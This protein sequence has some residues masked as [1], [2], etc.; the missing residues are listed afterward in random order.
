MKTTLFV[1]LILTLFGACCRHLIES[2][3]AKIAART[4]AALCSLLCLIV[5]AGAARGGVQG[6]PALEFQDESAAFQ[7]LSADT[8]D[9]VCKEA[10]RLLA[11][12]LTDGIAKTCGHTPSSCR[13]AIDRETLCVTAV[14]V[15]FSKED[16]L[17]SSYEVKNYVR[18]Q[19]GMEAAVEVM[20]E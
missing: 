9:A 1:C 13:T 15:R 12:R 16:L 2:A 6:F 17:L 20:F 8:M 7:S 3:G 4:F 19:C 10:E 5:L 14:T 18:A 11:E